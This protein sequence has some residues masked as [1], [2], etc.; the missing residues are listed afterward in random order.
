MKQYK[1]YFYIEQK[2]ENRKELASCCDEMTANFLFDHY[3][4]VY[5]NNSVSAKVIYKH[6]GKEQVICTA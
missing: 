1:H 3:R 4:K 6:K 2:E 5:L